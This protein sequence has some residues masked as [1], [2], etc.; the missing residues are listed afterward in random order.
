MIAHSALLHGGEASLP[1]L[2]ELFDSLAALMSYSDKLCDRS[3]LLL[4]GAR[5]DWIPPDSQAVHTSV[6]VVS[7]FTH[8]L[9]VGYM[10]EIARALNR[11]SEAA[12]YEARLASNRV[13]FDAHFWRNGTLFHPHR[14]C[15]SSGSQVGRPPAAPR[16]APPARAAAAWRPLAACVRRARRF[17]CLL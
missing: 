16:P 7:A 5:G 8:T 3:G 12:T 9:C 10:A 13:A 4:R 15:Y 2:D 6:D 14:C 11:T 17:V 1:A